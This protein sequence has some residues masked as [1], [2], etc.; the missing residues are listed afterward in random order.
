MLA[1]FNQAAPKK[2]LVEWWASVQ[3]EQ[4]GLRNFDRVFN[5]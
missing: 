2:P 3:T 1:D 4:D 5:W